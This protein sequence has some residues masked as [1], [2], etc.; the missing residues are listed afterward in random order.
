MKEVQQDYSSGNL[1]LFKFAPILALCYTVSNFYV[2]GVI[3]NMWNNFDLFTFLFSF[4]HLPIPAYTVA[5]SYYSFPLAQLIIYY[6]SSI[7]TSIANVLLFFEAALT[8]LGLF[9]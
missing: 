4:A 1:P 3:L 7:V 2:F 9:A 8:V 5:L 6:F